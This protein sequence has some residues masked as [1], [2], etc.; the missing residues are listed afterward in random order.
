MVSENYYP[1]WHA[2]VDGRRVPVGRADYVFIGVGLP[3]GARSLELSFS[4]V[5]YEQGLAVTLAARAVAV[6]VLVGGVLAG[7]RADTYG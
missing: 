1:G 3:A 7:R 4:S 2:T 6:L 5:R